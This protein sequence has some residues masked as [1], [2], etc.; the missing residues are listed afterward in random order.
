[1]HVDREKKKKKKRTIRKLLGELTRKE[2][3][4]QVNISN[5]LSRKLLR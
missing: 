4:Q 3:T 5:A 2:R 1:M